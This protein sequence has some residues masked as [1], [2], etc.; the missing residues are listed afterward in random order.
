MEQN[1]IELSK[2]PINK[3]LP[4][5]QRMNEYIKNIKN[6]YFFLCNG[7][8]VRIEFT[9]EDITL[10]ELVTNFLISKK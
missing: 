2:I 3:N 6:P 1:N 7:V 10:E 5:P 8:E 4:K 9:D